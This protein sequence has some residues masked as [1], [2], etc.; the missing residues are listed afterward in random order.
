M[1]SKRS[2]AARARSRL[3]SAVKLARQQS[4]GRASGR[5]ELARPPRPLTP[6]PRRVSRTRAGRRRSH[7]LNHGRGSSQ[8]LEK[9]STPTSP[10][11]RNLRTC[12]TCGVRSDVG[13]TL[14]AP[15]PSAWEFQR[16]LADHLRVRGIACADLV[17]LRV[18]TEG[19]E[20]GLMVVQQ[21]FL[22]AVEAAREYWRGRHKPWP[23][24]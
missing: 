22:S 21:A 18:M 9:I 7:T 4:G 3:A 20:S 17:A 24:F 23:V 13:R 8:T 19:V 11:G 6:P 10:A 5:A 12:P 15:A 1:S 14:Q 2:E 16:V